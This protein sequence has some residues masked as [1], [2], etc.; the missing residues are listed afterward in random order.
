MFAGSS[1]AGWRG[2]VGLVPLV[3]PLPCLVWLWREV[4]A[5]SQRAKGFICV[6]GADL[7]SGKMWY[8]TT[9]FVRLYLFGYKEID[10]ELI[11]SYWV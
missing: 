6:Y 11:I 1:G 3:D 7:C 5:L 2:G 4:L 9:S 10:F 8:L